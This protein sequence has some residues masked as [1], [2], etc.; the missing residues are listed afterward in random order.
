MY[1]CEILGLRRTNGGRLEGPETVSPQAGAGYALLGKE[2]KDEMRSQLG[3]G[4]LKKQTH[5]RKAKLAVTPSEDATRKNSQI[6]FILST[7]RKT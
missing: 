3:T 4:K 6:T 1:G 7:D 2:R 5:E